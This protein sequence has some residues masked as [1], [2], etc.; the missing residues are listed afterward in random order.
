MSTSKVFLTTDTGS[1]TLGY[2]NGL[3]RTS[4][5]YFDVYETFTNVNSTNWTITTSSGSSSPDR[6]HGEI[7]KLTA[8]RA[9]IAA[10]ITGGLS[11]SDYTF[12][13]GNTLP[14]S[15]SRVAVTGNWF[16]QFSH[17]SGGSIQTIYQ[18][19]TDTNNGTSG[20]YQR[21]NLSGAAI[22]QFTA[23]SFTSTAT[24]Y[25]NI[26]SDVTGGPS[27]TITA[28]PFFANL[29]FS[30]A[31]KN[32]NGIFSSTDAA[33]AYFQM[34]YARQYEANL[35]VI[36]GSGGDT[37]PSIT[38]DVTFNINDVLIVK[39][40]SGNLSIDSATSFTANN[41]VGFSVLTADYTLADY[42]D[43]DYTV[44]GTFSESVTQT[45]SSEATL[46]CL[47]GI[48]QYA[49]NVS[50][51]IANA[52]VAVEGNLTIQQPFTQTPSSEFSYTVTGN[53]TIS[54]TVS[55][56][57]DT[58]LVSN[59]QT[60]I[61]AAST[62]DFTATL[63]VTPEVT[64]IGTILT[65]TIDSEFGKRYTVD[66]YIAPGYALEPE[67]SVIH[68]DTLAYTSDVTTS[69][70][71]NVDN[72]AAAALTI[73]TTTQIETTVDHIVAANISADAAIQGTGGYLKT[74]GS[75]TLSGDTAA[76]ISQYITG[77]TGVILGSTQASLAITGLSL[78]SGSNL[79]MLAQAVFDAS[80]AIFI[81]AGKLDYYS[82]EIV[83]GGSGYVED[84]YA[85]PDYF[86]PAAIGGMSLVCDAT[87]GAAVVSIMTINT[88]WQINAGYAIYGNTTVDLFAMTMTLGSTS[89]IVKSDEYYTYMVPTELRQLY[90]TPRLNVLIVADEQRINMIQ[91]EPRLTTIGSE[92]RTLK[93]NM[94][95][96]TLVG[97]RIRRLA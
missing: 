92:T 51:E 88:S 57:A 4:F 1:A 66:D 82:A 7:M 30:A 89:R 49:G 28:N 29:F 11:L 68:G 80:L 83:S 45:E 78:T 13:G 20:Y 60:S 23:T 70:F 38:S 53:L 36:D 39:F 61:P 97:P 5:T 55:L 22:P 34:S 50:I 2:G 19:Q 47:G 90:I 16:T 14:S 94:A 81:Q 32:S 43:V 64:A 40:G 41:T 15:R 8:Q 12:P 72:R 17:T 75:L 9:N 54:D 48:A 52:V 25:S 85:V 33:V 58:T 65:L 59:S 96:G 93:I 6:T 86:V 71:G 42:I 18:F 67:S 37:A 44:A 69:L 35:I 3:A 76:T 24:T 56:S 73:D 74:S 87:I 26:G 95:P 62:I 77:G 63:A 84:L 79:T 10:V 46:V 27:D 91:A 31:T 21:T